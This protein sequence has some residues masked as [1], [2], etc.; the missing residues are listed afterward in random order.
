[1]IYDVQLILESAKGWRCAVRKGNG[2]ERAGGL[3][4]TEIEFPSQGATLRGLL[5]L[6]PAAKSRPATVIMAHGTSGTIGMVANEYARTFC[7]A[8]LA[9]L[10]YDHRNFGR[11]G[12][13]PRQEI[14]P[15][16]QCRGYIDA[17]NFVETLGHLDVS[18]M[19]L[20]GDSYSG[21]EVVVV[22]ACDRR[23]RAIVAQCP[24]FGRELPSISPSREN[25]EIIK[26]TLLGGDVRGTAE[27]T[28]GPMPV[29]SSDQRGTPSL[30]EPIQAFRW[31]IDYGGRPGSGWVNNATRVIPPTPVTYSPAACA[32]FLDAPT[33]LMVAAEDEMVHAN[34]AVTKYA[35]GLMPEP[36]RWYDI[37]DGHFGLLYFPS[38]RF[39][40]AS[41]IQAEFLTD[42]PHA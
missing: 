36:K 21:G 7:G 24:V 26:D 40:E 28:T 39:D 14:N 37:K 42:W 41:H 13:Q 38:E 34:Y 11:S 27:T 35:Y 18:R 3:A 31:F 12:G 2:L 23:A 22:G 19:A 1:M 20:W 15:W 6:P 32:P 25:F 30:L 17:M 4:V 5:F 33:L 9:V 10:L 8:G 29:V 16:I